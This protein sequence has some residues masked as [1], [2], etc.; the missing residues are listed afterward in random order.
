MHLSY[1]GIRVTDLDRSLALYRDFFGLQVV[2][3]GDNTPFGGGRYVLLKDPRS[4]QRLELNWY[5]PASPYSTPYASGEGLDHVA[6]RVDD[7]D[8]TVRELATRGLEA[9]PIRPDLEE[10]RKDRS[11][12]GWF[13]VAYVADP[14]G[15]WIEIYQHARPEPYDPDGY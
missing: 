4:G 3:Q 15:N 13:K 1:V 2:R 11:A 10:P 8:A 6:F 14:D 9:V 5:P 12:P 7:V